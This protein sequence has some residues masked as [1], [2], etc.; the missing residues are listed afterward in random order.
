MVLSVILLFHPKAPVVCRVLRAP[1]SAPGLGGYSRITPE[2]RGYPSDLSDAR[3]ALVEPTLATWRQ[4]RTA[5][6]LPHDH[7]PWET[8]YAYFAK[9]QRDGAFH[10]STDSCGACSGPPRAVI[11]SRR[12]A[13]STRR[14]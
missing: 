3:W 4:E 7:P 8:V 6:H 11:R 9:W 13:S 2:R 5:R 1:V 12:P 10:S 14:A